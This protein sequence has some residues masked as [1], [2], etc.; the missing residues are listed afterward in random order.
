MKCAWM[1]ICC[2]MGSR[3]LAQDVPYPVLQE[4][5]DAEGT[6]TEA[7]WRELAR[8]YVSSDRFADACWAWLQIARQFKDQAAYERALEIARNA[9]PWVRAWVHQSVAEAR[10]PKDA[11][12]HW[13]ACLALREGSHPLLRASTHVALG[14][15]L[16][17]S[18]QWDEAA[19]Q[20]QQA[21]MLLK[22]DY[23]DTQIHGVALGFLG[24]AAQKNG[25]LTKARDLGE[26][27]CVILR[28][29]VPDHK[30]LAT[31]LIN[32]GETCR[33]QGHGAEAQV[34]VEEARDIFQ[35]LNHAYGAA[36]TLMQLGFLAHSRL[37]Y[38]VAEAYYCKAEAAFL[39]L[40][41]KGQLLYITNAMGTV[42]EERGDFEEAWALYEE[43]LRLA[44]DIGTN[45]RTLVRSLANMA[46]L[47]NKRKDPSLALALTDEALELL[48]IAKNEKTE[49]WLW[50]L[51]GQAH[52]ANG[53][54]SLSLQS[55]QHA[56]NLARDNSPQGY[57]AMRIHH[58]L[59]LAYQ[60]LGQID[61]AE[62]TW[63]QAI[64]LL[65]D[66]DALMGDDLSL[67]QF[68]G[69]FEA[70]YKDLID[71]LLR[72]GR[73]SEAFTVSESYRGQ[74]F[75]RM[76]AGRDLDLKQIPPEHQVKWQQKRKALQEA[77]A[78]VELAR[79]GK[80]PA[81]ISSAELALARS[82]AEHNQVQTRMR[83]LTDGWISRQKPQPLSFED[84]AENLGDNTLVL[85][86]I[87]TEETTWLLVFD[88]RMNAPDI[89]RITLGRK[90]LAIHVQA[91]REIL[92]EGIHSEKAQQDLERRAQLL[93][94]KLMSAVDDLL[95]GADRLVILPDGPLHQLPFAALIR[96]GSEGS[97]QYLGAWKPL[98]KT[99]SMDLYGQKASTYGVNKGAPIFVFAQQEPQFPGAAPLPHALRE[100]SSIANAFGKRVTLF[101]GVGA[102]ESRLLELDSPLH[103]L[104]FAG[105]SVMQPAH[106]LE[107]SLHL[108][109]DVSNDGRL[110]M[111]EIMEQL[112]L[113]VDL[114]VLSGCETA[115]GK[116]MAGEG[117]LGMARA[118][119]YAGARSVLA[120][121]WRL[122]DR[123][124]ADVMSVFYQQ[125]VM[126]Y[127]PAEALQ[128][129]RQVMIVQGVPVYHWA[130]LALMGP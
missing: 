41:Q 8:V 77:Y 112:C 100:A 121:L 89:V 105:H 62:A 13:E 54:A 104:H 78:A 69:E 48:T 59:G 55:L 123:A 120:S 68:R 36:Y 3:A 96:K 92:A 129:T 90:Q 97:A 128:R 82:L 106:P 56:S 46:G 94:E 27:A 88:G 84:M 9:Q 117:Y 98:R 74:V 26:R 31:A 93:Y 91:F 76:L 116:E 52:L 67:M 122:Q 110:Q 39:N 71:L 66:H 111:W 17:R 34:M 50:R 102:T 65:E 44:S 86:F 87:V 30:D 118:F 16:Q 18:G 5:A 40:N 57:E 38:D 115:L 99:L 81:D 63:Q 14:R 124:T 11:I 32:L 25:A 15:V 83:H 33:L 95:V 28:N 37:E 73:G 108:A 47:A 126:G 51:R 85:D 6:T 130:G 23:H 19:F 2:L 80:E 72:Q 42:A 60:N 53:D 22:E 10:S 24:L 113:D 58:Q 21:H 109:G 49:T 64:G 75:M 127:E 103:I 125:L 43:A 7:Q 61:R 114:V 101:T 20:W 1:I 119:R 12:P 4:P 45:P 79:L 70:V 29:L 107:S 35:R